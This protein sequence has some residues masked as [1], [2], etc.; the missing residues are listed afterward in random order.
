[1][2]DYARAEKSQIRY[3]FYTQWNPVFHG[4]AGYDI[5]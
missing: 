5:S 3:Y 1:M 2:N 4:D